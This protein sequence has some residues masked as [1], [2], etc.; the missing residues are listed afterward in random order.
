MQKRGCFL[1]SGKVPLEKTLK[2]SNRSVMISGCKPRILSRE[3]I[4]EGRRDKLTSTD[5]SFRMHR[6]R[7]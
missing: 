6:L 2:K 7:R 1:T 5:R 4:A 3:S